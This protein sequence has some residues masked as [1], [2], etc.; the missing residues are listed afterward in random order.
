MTEVWLCKWPNDNRK[1][2]RSV[3]SNSGIV[4]RPE[5]RS[6]SESAQVPAGRIRVDVKEAE[7]P[8][9]AAKPRAVGPGSGVA[10]WGPRHA[11][12]GR[13]VLHMSL[14]D[15]PPTPKRSRRRSGFLRK[16]AATS[17]PRACR[18][19]RRGSVF[20][21]RTRWPRGSRNRR[22]PHSQTNICE[23]FVCETEI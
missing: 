13:I 15:R 3:R 12:R 16:N 6:A 11:A 8:T 7:R 18:S 10:G 1:D 17:S 23:T 20:T 22:R 14:R 2:E 9:R 5:K 21:S 4:S 19:I